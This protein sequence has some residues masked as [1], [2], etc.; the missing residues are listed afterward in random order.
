MGLIVTPQSEIDKY[1]ASPALSQS[2]LK[3]LGYGLDKYLAT[4]RKR[5]E[6]DD[7]VKN[8][9]LFGGA[10]DCILTGEEQVFN[11]TYYTSNLLKKPSDAE[12]AMIDTVFELVTTVVTSNMEEIDTLETYRGF[13]DTAV[14]K[15]DWYKGKPGD[16][17]IAGLIERGSEYFEDLKKA[18]GK[19]ILTSTQKQMID[20]VVH[21]FRTNPR[22]SK[23]FDRTSLKDD[24]TVDI[25]YQ[26]PIYFELKGIKCKALLDFLLVFKDKD[27]VIISIQPFDVKTKQGYTIEFPSSAKSYRYDFQAAWYSDALLNP[28]AIFPKGFP[29][30]YNKDGYVN[31][32]LKPFTFIVESSTEPGKPLVF[33]TNESFIDAGR[34]GVVNPVTG[35]IAV[36]GYHALLDDYNYY[37]KTEWKEEKI[38][39]DN[40]GVLELNWDGIVENYAD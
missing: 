22:T 20:S 29:D 25:Y 36:N 35:K 28:T 8:H 37:A 21:S 34:N 39:T 10:V 31:V 15:H 18:F 4:I 13:I 33:K 17:R 12:V 27:G 1:F 26:L 7:S 19:K 23:Y 11:E 3:E 24:V 5:E 32:E 6:A 38:V 40:N 9:F 30:V 2:N 14:V 16:V